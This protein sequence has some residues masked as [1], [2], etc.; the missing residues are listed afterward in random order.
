MWIQSLSR[1]P[2]P[3]PNFNVNDPLWDLSLNFNFSVDVTL[4]TQPVKRFKVSTK[5]LGFLLRPN[6]STDTLDYNHASQG[7]LVRLKNVPNTSWHPPLPPSSLPSSPLPQFQSY[8]Q[9]VSQA[10]PGKQT[11][12]QNKIINIDIGG[13]G[14]AAKY[15]ENLCL[16]L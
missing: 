8:G 11:Q 2:S 7:F 5:S 10:L 3:S 12:I 15:F 9:L 4:Y 14:R 13:R 16:N 6:K 1:S